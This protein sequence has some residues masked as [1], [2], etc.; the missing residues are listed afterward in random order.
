VGAKLLNLYP[1]PNTTT[2]GSVPWQNN[3]IAGSNIRDWRLNSLI[4]RV[5]HNFGPRLRLMGRWAWNDFVQLTNNN[6]LPGVAGNY[7]YG[8]KANKEN[9]VIDSVVTIT[10]TTLLNI[11]ASM[12]HW[13]GD[14]KPY[15]PFDSLG[16]GFPKSLV[17]QLPRP[18]A[19]PLITIDGATTM[20]QSSGNSDY[21]GSAILSAVPNLVL[22]RGK[23]TIKTGL[24]FRQTRNALIQLGAAAGSYTFSRTFTRADY[25]VQDL[26][27]GVAA[28]SVL[29][30]DPS[31]GSISTIDPPAL[32]WLYF[33][34]WI[35]DDFKATRRLT[36]NFGFRWDV[37]MGVTE[38]Y[39]RINSGFN[40]D[41]VNPISEQI[42]K[43]KFPGYTVKGGL[44]FAGVGGS[45]RSPVDTDWNNLQIRIGAAYRLNEQT[46]LRGGYGT[47]Y[48][49]PTSFGN[50][51]GF[52]QTTSYVATLDSAAHPPTRSTIPSPTA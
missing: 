33:A 34:P 52:S 7:R 31:S 37:N 2:S 6:G 51:F 14:F 1:E 48:Q 28:A 12:N 30:G 8:S 20:G 29:L 39:N 18:T 4:A 22:I 43:T 36:I 11:R 15:V 3:Y 41:V 24:D 19:F 5:D 35:Q 10:P 46:V 32:Q 23:H 16:F 40:A 50:Q 17:N 45:S 9:V 44:T 27:S 38:R 47:F 26:L 42:D 49:N 13:V 21:E 25:L